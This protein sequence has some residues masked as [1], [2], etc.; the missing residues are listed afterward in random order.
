MRMVFSRKGFDS[1][2]GGG[3]SPIVDG[4]PISL[5]IPASAGLSR[6]SYGELGLA[7]HAAAA[8]RG[9]L[10]AADLCHH[11]PMFLPGK[12]AVL[13]Q[14]GA[15]QTH[16]ER[17][18]VGVGDCFV[19]FGLFQQQGERPH[20][21]IFAYLQIE[22]VLPLTD[23]P[24]ARLAELA[25]VGMPHAIGLHAAND[26][27]YIGTGQVAQRA[28]DSLRLTVPEGPPSLWQVPQWLFG[29]GLSYH[30]RADRWRDDNR[31]QSVARGQEFVADAGKRKDARDWLAGVIAEIAG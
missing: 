7:E 20:H 13:G 16:L 30:H 25:K 14:C 19:F 29:I 17:Q 3:P 11:D 28:S 22:E 9:K 6:T 10:G 8:S 26:T 27:A 1:S 21:R 4:R 23:A 2:A 18:G 31:L 24:P 5:P 12:R 15:A